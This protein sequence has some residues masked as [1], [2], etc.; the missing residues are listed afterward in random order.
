MKTN[1]GVWDMGDG[2]GD[3]LLLSYIFLKIRIKLSPFQ[4]EK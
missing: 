1:A 4:S 3:H 2:Q